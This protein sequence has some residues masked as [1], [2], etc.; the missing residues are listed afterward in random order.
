MTMPETF[1]V[2]LA[3]WVGTSSKLAALAF[4]KAEIS[5]NKAKNP[6]AIF[7]LFAKELLF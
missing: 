6:E 2:V 3:T 4:T 5:S 1:P 7:Y